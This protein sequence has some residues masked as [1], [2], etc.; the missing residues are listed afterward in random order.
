M[1]ALPFGASGIIAP[2]LELGIVMLTHTAEFFAELPL[3]DSAVAPPGYAALAL[4]VLGV[5]VG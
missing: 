5:V 1:P 2:M 4:L 3:A